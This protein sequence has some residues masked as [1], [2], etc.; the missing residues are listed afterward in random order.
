[1]CRVCREFAKLAR[2]RVQFEATATK[3]KA[4]GA[5]I[6]EFIEAQQAVGDCACGKCWLCRCKA[7]G[8]E[9]T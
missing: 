1:V 9:V 3:A 2:L 7:E 6:R 4:A 8:L 5:A